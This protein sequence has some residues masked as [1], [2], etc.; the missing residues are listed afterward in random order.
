MS[1]KIGLLV[2]ITALSLTQSVSF[3]QDSYSAIAQ[4]I[5]KAECN[6]NYGQIACGYNC[7]ANYGV[8]RCAEWPGGVCEANYGKVVCGPP[9]PP[10]WT[11]LYGNSNTNNVNSTVSRISW[12]IYSYRVSS[13]ECQKR[14]YYSMQNLGMVSLKHGEAN[15]FKYVSG[16]WENNTA[17][18]GCLDNN[19][20]VIFVVGSNQEYINNFRKKLIRNLGLQLEAF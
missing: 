5:P 10:N 9:A 13:I 2:T 11:S 1:K 4:N 3:A 7:V 20:L 16:N 19:T 14:A 15:R 18:I 6:S 12:S 17:R 8:V